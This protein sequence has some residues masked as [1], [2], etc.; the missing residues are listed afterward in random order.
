MKIEEYQ[1]IIGQTAVYPKQVDNFG[2]AYCWLGLLG[3]WNE[4]LNANQTNI[5]KEFGD[6]CWY[7]VA[8]CKEAD[9]DVKE[10]FNPNNIDS[11]Y[12][13]ISENIKKYYRDGKPLDKNNIIK[14]LSSK[15]YNGKKIIE[16][17]G[18]S[19][20]LEEILEINYNKLIKRRETNTLH[21]DGDNR[22]VTE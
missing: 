16:M 10:I 8:F 15:F 3:E 17:W 18:Y 1:K 19:F 4:F 7:L 11:H 13:D 21:G 6:F 20:D 14:A 12:Q 5:K 22:E 9:I 2:L